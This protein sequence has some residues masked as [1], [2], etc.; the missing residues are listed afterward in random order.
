MK[1]K[2]IAEILKEQ[3]YA[4][5]CIGKWHLGDQPDFLPTRHGFDSYFGIPSLMPWAT[6]RVKPPER[7]E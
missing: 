4:T 1:E 2:T 5:A 3:G 7:T 6:G